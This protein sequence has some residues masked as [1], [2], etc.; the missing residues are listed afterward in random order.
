MKTV[1]R[2][3]VVCSVLA[4]TGLLF[5]AAPA[6]AA[7]SVG[8]GITCDPNNPE[9]CVTTEVAGAGGGTTVTGGQF[10]AACVAETTGALTTSVTCSTGGNS[11]TISLPGPYGASAVTAPTSSLTG[12]E[13]CWSSTGFFIDPL[14]GVVTVTDSGCAIITI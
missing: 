3:A 6:N 14:G 4:V 11:R 2:L 9:F 13:V 5:P 12:H 10:A 8:V 7:V 1:R